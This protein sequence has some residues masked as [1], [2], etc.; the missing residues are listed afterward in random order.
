MNTL[1]Q[2]EVRNR[3]MQRALRSAEALPDEQTQHVLGLEGGQGA[4]APE[5]EEAA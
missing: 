3:A 4:S 5:E 2:A 1:D